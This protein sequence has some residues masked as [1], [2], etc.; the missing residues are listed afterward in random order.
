MAALTY[1]IYKKQFSVGAASEYD[2]LRT[3]VAMKN[4]EPE[5]LQADISIRQAELQLR[6][7]MGMP[8][9]F[10]FAV[11]GE[12]S[13]YEKRCTPTHWPSTPTIAKIHLCV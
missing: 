1:D 2:V 5:L 12:L 10:A 7:L 13:D 4:I 11:A 9:D 6:I 8:G 3:S